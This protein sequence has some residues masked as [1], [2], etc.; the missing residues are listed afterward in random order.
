M[1]DNVL[2]YLL[3]AALI[4]HTRLYPVHPRAI[5]LKYDNMAASS[6]QHRVTYARTRHSYRFS[7]KSY[8]KIS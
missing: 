7:N 4:Q 3:T 6:N 2:Y 5:V 8:E 1:C